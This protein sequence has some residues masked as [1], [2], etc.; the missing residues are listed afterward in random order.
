MNEQDRANSM[1]RDTLGSLV[2]QDIQARARIQAL[3]AE[4]EMLIKQVQE[5]KE[6]WQADH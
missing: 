2:L 5:R 1:L 3:E 4:R 6:S